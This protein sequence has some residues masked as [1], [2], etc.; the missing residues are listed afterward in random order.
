MKVFVFRHW[1]WILIIVVLS[2][3]SIELKNDKNNN[4]QGKIIFE[5]TTI[6]ENEERFD[7]ELNSFI[8]KEDSLYKINHPNDIMGSIASTLRL[9]LDPRENPSRFNTYYFP[10]KSVYSFTDTLITYNFSKFKVEINKS[11][12]YY[13]RYDIRTNEVTEV[14]KYLFYNP[15]KT[16]KETIYKDSIKNINGF[17]CY[18][19][20]I[21][22]ESNDGNFID[23]K[24]MFVTEKIN[25]PYHPVRIRMELL[26]KYYPLEIKIYSDFLKDKFT[27]FK[28]KLIEKSIP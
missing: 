4:F 26:E 2:C 3:K 1:S 21:S 16:Y 8:K 23:Y 19:V 17:N 11:T 9:E 15:Q 14:K 12:N 6:I 20:L 22:E 7:K 25:S 27:Y 18:K 10:Q 28:V 13:K 24:E 5:I